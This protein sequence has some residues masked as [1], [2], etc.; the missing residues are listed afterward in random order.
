VFRNG[1]SLGSSTYSA[2]EFTSAL[3]WCQNQYGSGHLDADI[4]AAAFYD[5][6]LSSTDRINVELGFAAKLAIA[7]AAETTEQIGF[8][9]PFDL[10]CVAMSASMGL[11]GSPTFELRADGVAVSG[12]SLAI[13][14]APGGQDSTMNSA[15]MAVGKS[16]Q[17]RSSG[18][19]ALANVTAILRRVAT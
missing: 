14:S 8:R 11:A 12:G 15:T 1:V 3:L 10:C 18:T 19:A 7:H 16:V 17:I 6:A 5:V 13:V 9:A 4:A 2:D